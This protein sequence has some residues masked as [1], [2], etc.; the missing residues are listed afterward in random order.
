MILKH[1]QLENYLKK[2]KQNHPS[3][4]LV[5]GCFDILHFGHVKF[6][7]KAKE[8]NDILI[9]LLENDQ[10]VKK[11]KGENRPIF[12][13]M[14]RAFVLSQIRFVDLVVLLPDNMKDTDYSSL[15]EMIRPN[16]IAITEHD[17]NQQK[18]EVQAKK[19]GANI[20]IIPHV[21]T[22]STSE[23]AKLLGID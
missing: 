5:G 23:L 11:L 3:I 18:K 20:K 2:L 10:R 12:R 16:V 19:I 4:V 9:V 22:Y 21:E 14:E 8:G 17:L 7:E 15:V 1:T 6:F 13:E